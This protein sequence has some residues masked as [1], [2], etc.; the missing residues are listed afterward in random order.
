MA[1]V[2]SSI[3]TLPGRPACSAYTRAS[4]RTCAV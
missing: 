1:S 3:S 4:E 2:T